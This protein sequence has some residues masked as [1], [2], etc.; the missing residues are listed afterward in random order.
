MKTIRIYEPG[1][2]SLDAPFELSHG[3]H[4]HVGVVLRMQPGETIT[5]FSGDNQEYTARI[6]E[7]H[8]KRTLVQIET[9]KTMNRESPRALHLGQGIAKGDR[10]EWIIQKAVELGVTSITPL[11]TQHGAVKQDPARLLKKQ[12]QWQAIAI[13]ACEQSGRNILPILHPIASFTSYVTTCKASLKFILE[14]NTPQSLRDYTFPPGDIA[15]MIGPE[16]GFH[17][18]ELNEAIQAQFKTL[19]LGPR[20][21]RTE[22]A[23]ISALSILQAMAGDL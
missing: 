7:T 11:L 22:T 19:N 14:P 13:S 3:A 18:D 15:L 21:L 17:T 4:Q 10:M 2:Y 5:L 16:G 20:I 12:A 8:K 9:F 6:M 1:P 23:A